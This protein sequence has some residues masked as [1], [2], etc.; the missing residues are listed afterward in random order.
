MEYTEY[1]KNNFLDHQ[2]LFESFPDYFKASALRVAKISAML[3]YTCLEQNITDDRL[4]VT[5]EQNLVEGIKYIMVGMVLLDNKYLL[6][7]PEAVPILRV[8]KLAAVG[9][10]ERFDGLGKPSKLKGSQIP[11]LS[12]IVAIVNYYD[13]YHELAVDD[14]KIINALNANKKTLFDPFLVDM[15]LNILPE[16]DVI[17]MGGSYIDLPIKHVYQDIVNIN[18]KKRALLN[19]DLVITDD[20]EGVLYP[21]Q[22]QVI[23]SRTNR[24]RELSK[25]NIDITEKALSNNKVELLIWIS[26]PHLVKGDDLIDRLTNSSF[27]QNMIIKLD[28]ADVKGDQAN[29]DKLIKKL[30]NKGLKIAINNFE[31]VS[32]YAMITK[33]E[34]DYLMLHKDYLEGNDNHF[35]LISSLIDI[36]RSVNT[37]IV[38]MG[39]NNQEDLRLLAG[40]EINLVATNM[41]K[42]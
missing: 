1:M 26:Y 19:A 30:K 35:K 13:V 7:E 8:A 16:I 2:A 34:F 21:E 14:D 36:C 41:Y 12:R 20:Q 38:V 28:A 40:Y 27:K 33:F 32:D 3:Y 24:G 31:M 18:K 10:N 25:V 22:Y 42:E 29:A 6:V 9:F 17:Y 11:L 39:I 37:E 15:F 4:S 5:D 23:A